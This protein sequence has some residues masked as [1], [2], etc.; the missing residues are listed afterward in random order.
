MATLKMALPT[1]VAPELSNP[2]RMS[3]KINVHTQ[4]MFS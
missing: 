2:G 4:D 1:V 3:P